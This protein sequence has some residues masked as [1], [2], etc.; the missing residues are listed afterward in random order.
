MHEISNPLDLRPHASQATRPRDVSTRRFHFATRVGPRRKRYL[1]SLRGDVTSSSARGARHLVK[2]DRSLPRARR[3]RCND[4]VAPRRQQSK[5]RRSAH[6]GVHPPA[7]RGRLT[8]HVATCGVGGATRPTAARTNR[9]SASP[10]HAASR[11]R[12]TTRGTCPRSGGDT[13]PSVAWPT[14]AQSKRHAALDPSAADEAAVAPTENEVPLGAQAAPQAVDAAR[15][16]PLGRG[17]PPEAKAA[18]RKA[19]ASSGTCVASAASLGQDAETTASPLALPSDRAPRLTPQRKEAV[20]G[21]GSACA[22]RT[23]VATKSKKTSGSGREA[24]S[25]PT[26]DR[27]LAARA[28]ASAGPPR[29]QSEA[30]AARP[31]QRPP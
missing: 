12:Y 31:R 1:L 28:S 25:E 23:K 19:S 21:I 2:A 29:P 22:A 4:T 14:V 30:E 11:T 3:R 7:Q 17:S 8:T 15:A 24:A 6:T 26:W 5:L 20:N 27:S 13:P 10:A 16:D 9:P 18:R